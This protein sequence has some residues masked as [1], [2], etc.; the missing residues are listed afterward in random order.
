MITI[1]LL[2]AWLVRLE[3]NIYYYSVFNSSE[4]KGA[5]GLSPSATISASRLF[6]NTN[7]SLS[8]AGPGVR[9]YNGL[10]VKLASSPQH[11]YL[12]KH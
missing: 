12:M 8:H 11:L 10:A 5:G 1:S 7:M 4:Q 9:R 3:S 2:T 6:T